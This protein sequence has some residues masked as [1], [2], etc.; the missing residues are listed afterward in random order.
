LLQVEAAEAVD[1]LQVMRLAAEFS[2]PL[3]RL[4]LSEVALFREGLTPVGSLR[5]LLSERPVS[6]RLS[7]AATRWLRSKGQ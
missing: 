1:P 6:R 4:V 5:D 2:E 7:Q 3:N